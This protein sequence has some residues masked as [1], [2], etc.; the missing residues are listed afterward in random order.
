MSVAAGRSRRAA[1]ALQRDLGFL[2]EACHPR[3][4]MGTNL[5]LTRNSLAPDVRATVVALLNAQ[6][7][8]LIDLQSQCH[9]AHWN[10]RGRA[11]R[12]LHK[13][14][15]DLA[16]L[17]G[18]HVDETAERITTLGGD[19]RGTVRMAGA[20]SPLPEYPDRLEND[21]EHVAA[22]VERFA[23][24]AAL[25]RQA[26]DRAAGLGDPG[27]ADLLTGLSRDLDKGLWFL[28]AHRP[29]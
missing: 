24:A 26:V 19:A 16:D 29:A 2:R 6:L 18:G 5:H 7:A 10:V 25:V 23:E 15:D 28:E 17:V 11:F 1:N 12:P 21:I 22:L 3:A 9:Q 13:L 8:V 14:F 4:I 27:S 20:A